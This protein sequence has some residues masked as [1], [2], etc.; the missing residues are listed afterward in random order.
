MILKVV[1][2]DNPELIE[3]LFDNLDLTNWILNAPLDVQDD[4]TFVFHRKK[5]IK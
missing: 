2:D 1:S 4:E 3:Y 5:E